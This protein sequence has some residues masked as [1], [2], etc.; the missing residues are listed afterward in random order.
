MA[1]H[2][3]IGRPHRSGRNKIDPVKMSYATGKLW[4]RSGTAAI[5]ERIE[6]RS[7]LPWVVVVARKVDSGG[8]DISHGG[9]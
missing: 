5:H 8:W 4:T 9:I 1:G 2:L 6:H 7:S 3:G